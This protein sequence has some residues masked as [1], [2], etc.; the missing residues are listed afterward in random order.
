[1]TS[2]APRRP[3]GAPEDRFGHSTTVTALTEPGTFGATIEQPWWVIRG[4]HGGFLAA[5][6][7]RAMTSAVEDPA[8]P[9]RSF[10]THFLSAPSLGPISVRTTVERTG[11]SA[12]FVSA[13]AEQQGRTFALSLAAFSRSFDGLAFDDA[14]MP[15][16]PPPEEVPVLPLRED[17][18]PYLRNFEVRPALGDRPF[19]GS[20]R[21]EVGGWIRT[22]DTHVADAPAVAA[23]M[24]AWIPSVFPR[25]TSPV[26]CPTIDLTVHFLGPLPVEGARPEDR[27]LARF[28]SSTARDGFFVEDGDLWTRDG[29]LIALSRQLALGMPTPR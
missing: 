10:T 17:V 29:R 28:R 21:A 23:I 22:A 27:Y 8:R 7:L 9:P 6:I 20:D 19:T 12:T 2:S 11:A 15:E 24:D 5:V 18:P 25:A 16:V 4:P 26:V 1:V 3:D 14:T 13:R